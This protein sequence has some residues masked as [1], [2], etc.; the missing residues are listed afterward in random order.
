MKP[1]K[2]YNDQI[3]TLRGRGVKIGNGN[4]KDKRIAKKI[5]IEENYY[6][7]INGYKDLFLLS[8]NPEKYKRN[9]NFF[10]I[11]ALYNFDRN[12]RNI[13]LKKILKVENKLKS[14]IAYTFANKYGNDYLNIKNYDVILKTDTAYPTTSDNIEKNNEKLNEVCKLIN[15]LTKSLS[16]NVL[17]KQYLNHS[18]LEHEGV[19]MWVLVNI[20][21]MGTISK[22]YMYMKKSDRIEVSKYFNVLESHLGKYI[23]LINLFRNICA[24]EERCYS[25][26]VR[27]N[28]NNTIHH[29][30]L[31]LK[32]DKQRNYLQG[33]KDVFA[34]LITMKELLSKKDYNILKLKLDKI[35]LE[36]QSKLNT[37]SINDV[38]YKM[39][40][41]SNWKD[42]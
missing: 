36:L 11:Y 21:T 28:I 8:I 4:K 13:F 40:F 18:L 17:K 37:I 27:G 22:F 34:L 9:T 29:R 6:S 3:R 5:L 19:P 35:I 33:K 38:L 25:E 32:Q 31:K 39:G 2:T 42:L 30:R 26:R 23:Y 16:D 20:L 15:F 41:P 1:F 24:H 14:V 7:L 10:E 12:L